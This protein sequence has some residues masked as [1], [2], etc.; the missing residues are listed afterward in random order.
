MSFSLFR[1]GP[2]L[3]KVLLGGTILTSFHGFKRRVFRAA[4]CRAWQGRHSG[5]R[6]APA[7]GGDG[8][9]ARRRPLAVAYPHNERHGG[10]GFW[11]ITPPGQ[12]PVGS[13]AA[14]RAAGSWQHLNG[15]ADCRPLGPCRPWPLASIEPSQATIDGLGK[16]LALVPEEPPPP[17][18]DRWPPAI[19]RPM[20]VSLVIRRT[21]VRCTR[22][23]DVPSWNPRGRRFRPRHSLVDGAIRPAPGPGAICLRRPPLQYAGGDWPR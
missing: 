22:T 6:P 1:A 19:A 16:A 9:A 11:V 14:G 10:D 21:S 5:G 15:T 13:S 17:L 8:P 20:T 7:I 4:S 23:R 3:P 2:L 18:S 12:A